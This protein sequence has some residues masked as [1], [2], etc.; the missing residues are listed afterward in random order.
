MERENIVSQHF[1]H[2]ADQTPTGENREQALL[3][4]IA[5]L[6]EENAALK[7]RLAHE[8][9]EEQ[10]AAERQRAREQEQQYGIVYD[11]IPN[12][13]YPGKPIVLASHLKKHGVTVYTV[14]HQGRLVRNKEIDGA[15][16]VG[17]AALSP[18]GVDQLVEYQ[19]NSLES[20]KQSGA[21][22]RQPGI[23]KPRRSAKS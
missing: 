19:R 7:A 10:K 13:I 22:G 18:M 20:V 1:A 8:P 5:A 15:V 3:A 23:K 4:R 6:E 12:N 14:I 2:T 16:L 17:K 11:Y 21:R 9:T